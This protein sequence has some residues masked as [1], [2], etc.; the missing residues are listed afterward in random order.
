MRILEAFSDD[1]LVIITNEGKKTF[2]VG[3][4]ISLTMIDGISIFGTIL[5][6]DVDSLTIDFNNSERTYNYEKLA[7]LN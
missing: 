5:K 7:Y 1:V 4:Y 6:I 2:Q 3:D